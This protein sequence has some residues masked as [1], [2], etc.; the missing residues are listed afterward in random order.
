MPS[1]GSSLT[2]FTT[3]TLQRGGDE[4]AET[5]SKEAGENRAS[6]PGR[7]SDRTVGETLH[8]GP[9]SEP[10]D[11]GHAGWTPLPSPRPPFPGARALHREVCAHEISFLNSSNRPSPPPPPPRKGQRRVLRWVLSPLPTTQLSHPR[12]RHLCALRFP[13]PKYLLPSRC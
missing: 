8:R 6:C 12:S 10:L 7:L 11:P 9:A 13:H 4:S 2:A 3:H 5:S 1:D